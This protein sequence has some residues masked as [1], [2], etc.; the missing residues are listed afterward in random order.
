MNF[1]QRFK[2]WLTEGRDILSAIV[3]S[4]S[5]DPLAW[6][7]SIQ[8]FEAH[9]R[10]APPP[11]DV[12]VFTGSSS[13]TYWA[14]L[15]QDMAPLPVIN[16]GFGGS[17]IN[18]VVHYANRIVTPYH[19][20]AVVLFAGTND[21]SGSK[22][23]TAQEVFESYRAFV[24]VVHTTLPDTPIYY[25]SI[26]PT[27]SRWKYWPIVN[28]TN[29]L[30]KA[31]T[32]AN[33]RLHFIDMTATILGRDGKPDRSLFRIDRLH[34]NKK[35]YAKWTAVIKPILQAGFATQPEQRIP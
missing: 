35:G 27:P 20:R 24:E 28:E 1:W 25:L 7:S 17:R 14:T 31:Y 10:L 22:P 3:R 12:I 29:R 19:P 21:I 4:L 30:I 11:P 6:E 34:P 13:I 16:R 9:D 5:G 18:D 8:K 26:T 15:E 32:E 2:Q 33:P 23:K